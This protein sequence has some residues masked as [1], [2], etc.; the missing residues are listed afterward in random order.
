MILPTN[1]EEFLGILDDSIYDYCSQSEGAM[2]L[3]DY[4]ALKA[5]VV[6]V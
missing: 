2:S 5:F 1:K 4:H 6:A 3:T